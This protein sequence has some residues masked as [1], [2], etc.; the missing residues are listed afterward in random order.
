MAEWLNVAVSKTVVLARVPG[1][2]PEPEGERGFVY[3]RSNETKWN[4][5]PSSSA[6]SLNTNLNWRVFFILAFQSI[7]VAL[8]GVS[9]SDFFLKTS[10]VMSTEK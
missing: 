8:A 5:N 6:I 10:R 7:C 4:G 3:A 9:L 1:V 2:R